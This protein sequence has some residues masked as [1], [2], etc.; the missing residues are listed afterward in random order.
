[1]TTG[2]VIDPDIK[3][4]ELLLYIAEQTETDP[5]AGSTKYNKIL[6]F[7]ELLHMRRQGRPI[8][9]AEYTKNDQGPTLHHMLP[10]VRQLEEADEARVVERDYYGNT[11]KRLAALRRP[12][13]DLFSASEIAAIDS[14]IRQMWGKTAKEISRL[15]HDDLGWR[16]VDM[17]DQIPLT[18]AFIVA[19]GVVTDE[20]R[21]RAKQFA[22]DFNA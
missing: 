12:N 15:S 13:L 21:Q 16:A 22:A 11:Q 4:A 6:Y 20:M 10:I 19:D 7:G 18:M 14:L 2:A 17:G 1:M 3:A 9:G 5:T 8:T